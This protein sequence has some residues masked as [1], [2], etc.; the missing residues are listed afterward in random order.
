MTTYVDSS[1]LVAV[2]V[3]ER[4]SATARRAVQE[5]SQVRP[6]LHN[7]EVLNAFE[8]LVGRKAIT[9]DE[10]RAVQDQLQDDIVNH[11]LVR[12]TSIDLD[13]VFTN[14]SEL[15]RVC[16]A[17]MLTQTLNSCTSRPRISRCAPPSSPRTIANWRSPRRPA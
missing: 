12:S 11:R 10:C 2:Y 1:A 16:T 15:S 9:R 17:K 5:A 14:A 4:F 6:A 3:P 13:Q 7:L 8:S